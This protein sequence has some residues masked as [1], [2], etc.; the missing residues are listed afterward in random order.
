MMLSTTGGTVISFDIFSN[1]V[2]WVLYY[3][4]HLLW[5]TKK[6]IFFL[7]IPDYQQ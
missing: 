5:G 4:V 2:T 1:P 3:R 6:D 7:L